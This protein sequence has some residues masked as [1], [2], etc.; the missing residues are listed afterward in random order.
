MITDEALFVRLAMSHVHEMK[1]LTV[2]LDAEPESD[3]LR[4]LLEDELSYG[5][6]LKEQTPLSWRTP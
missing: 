4:R 5:V 6:Y 2:A 3:E 1:R